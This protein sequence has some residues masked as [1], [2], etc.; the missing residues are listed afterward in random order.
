MGNRRQQQEIPLPAR[1]KGIARQ[2]LVNR[3]RQQANRLV[4]DNAREQEIRRVRRA[5][6]PNAGDNLA[7]GWNYFD[8]ILD[9]AT[10]RFW[11]CADPNVPTWVALNP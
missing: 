5:G 3:R 4:E 7:A 2:S 1:S 6:A 8:E 11:K 10:N 9:T